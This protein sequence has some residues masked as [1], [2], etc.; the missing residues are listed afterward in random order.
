MELIHDLESDLALAILL[1]KKYSEKI[2][3]KDVVSLVTRVNETLRY[4]SLKDHT[5][6][7]DQ[8]ALNIAAGTH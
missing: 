5:C 3:A 8:Q 2:E 1:E 6:S 4:V 7:D